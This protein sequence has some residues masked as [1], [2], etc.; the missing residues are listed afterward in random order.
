V[1]FSAWNFVRDHE[2]NSLSPSVPIS[3]HRSPRHT[4]SL[5]GFVRTRWFGLPL[6][7]HGDPSGLDIRSN[8]DQLRRVCPNLVVHPVP[9]SAG[10]PQEM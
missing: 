9:V 1:K 3:M 2:L 4:E 7:A 8:V 5:S 10:S 6:V